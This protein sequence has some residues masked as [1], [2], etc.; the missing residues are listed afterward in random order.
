MKVTDIV[1]FGKYKGKSF[2]EL[3]KDKGYVKFILSNFERNSPQKRE[4]IDF[5][6]T[7]TSF[8]ENKKLEGS[9]TMRCKSIVENRDVDKFFERIPFDKSDIKCRNIITSQLFRNYIAKMKKVDASLAG[10]YIDYYIRFIISKKRFTPFHDDRVEYVIS[11]G[12]DCGIDLSL[13]SIRFSYEYVN[14]PSLITDLGVNALSVYSLSLCHSLYFGRLP[15]KYLEMIPIIC[16]YDFGFFVDELSQIISDYLIPQNDVEVELNPR[17]EYNGLCGDPDLII[18]EKLIDIK[19]TSYPMSNYEILQLFGYFS[20]SVFCGKKVTSLSTFNLDKCVIYSIDVSS[21][22]NE[23]VSEILCY[24]TEEYHS[25]IQNTTNISGIREEKNERKCK[26]G[27]WM[28]SLLLIG[29]GVVA[30]CYWW[31]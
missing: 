23:N 26:L 31:V 12:R 28:Y 21:L 16:E 14:S 18:G 7:F 10:I 30:S 3:I 5:L 6:K 9:L 19:L 11:N 1:S 20:L 13:P 17:F 24:F 2:D 8:D 25:E 27:K 22:N 4:M 29:A 15:E